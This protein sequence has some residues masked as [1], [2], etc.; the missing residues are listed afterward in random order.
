LS[1]PTKKTISH[2]AIFDTF[3]RLLKDDHAL[4]DG[5]KSIPTQSLQNGM[6]FLHLTTDKGTTQVI[7]FTVQH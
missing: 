4:L 1:I 7:P 6:F 2:W 5:I 3:G